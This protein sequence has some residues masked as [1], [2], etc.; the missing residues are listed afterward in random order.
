MRGKILSIGNGNYDHIQPNLTNAIS[1]ANEIAQ[2]FGQ[3]GYEVQ[4]CIDQN[5]AEII[6]QVQ[7][8]SNS[9]QDGEI[10]V[11]YYAGHGC[12]VVDNNGLVVNCIMGKDSFMNQDNGGEVLQTS[13]KLQEHI[14][15]LL[16]SSKAIIKIFL[17]DA[18]R[19]EIPL[20]RGEN[21]PVRTGFSFNIKSAGGSLISFSTSSSK[22]ASDGIEGHSPYAKAL[23]EYCKQ[24]ISI[25]DCLKKVRYSVFVNT[26]NCQITWEHTSLMGNFQFNY[27]NMGGNRE[28]NLH[29]EAHEDIY[30]YTQNVLADSTYIISPDNQVDLIIQKLKTHDW[31]KQ[32]DGINKL[33]GIGKEEATPNQQ[34]IIGR[35][36][37][38]TAI[39]GEYECKSIMEGRLVNFLTRWSD[40]KEN[41]ILN[42]MLFEM[43]FDHNAEFRGATRTKST[44]LIQLLMLLNSEQF[45]KSRSFIQQQLD[46]YRGRLYYFPLENKSISIQ[47]RVQPHHLNDAFME[48]S[49]LSVNGH[50]IEVV[51]TENMFKSFKNFELI[52]KQLSNELCAPIDVLN[53]SIEPQVANDV[54]IEFPQDLTRSLNLN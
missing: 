2:V 25:E 6:D 53:L 8:F 1:D 7:R 28:D 14:I 13:I 51:E 31:Y 30:I 49:S 52:K 10:A 35:N 29:A 5:A 44:Y 48:F 18:C 41:H 37:L 32:N 3:M 43:Y 34:F 42:G 12:Q 47:V 54:Q 22:G 39:G 50:E 33:Y 20:N 46:P 45:E 40:N 36:I 24:S 19:K 17:I 38:Q 26:G 27:A 21:Q 23:L 11:L 9:L 4:T 15:D 16:D